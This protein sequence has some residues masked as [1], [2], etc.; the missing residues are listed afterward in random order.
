MGKSDD[1]NG[2]GTQHL[3]GGV[4]RNLNPLTKIQTGEL[5]AVK[6]EC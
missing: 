2:R 4:E 3:L 5:P 1:E 6:Q